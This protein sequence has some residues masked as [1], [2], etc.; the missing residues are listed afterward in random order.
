MTDFLEVIAWYWFIFIHDDQILDQL[1]S[2][3]I[4]SSTR[5]AIASLIG[6]ETIPRSKI[7]H[8]RALQPVNQVRPFLFLLK[9]LAY[10]ETI[11]L[12]KDT[13]RIYYID[14]KNSFD[15]FIVL[16]RFPQFSRQVFVGPINTN[17]AIETNSSALN[18][19]F[20]DDYKLSSAPSI[21]TAGMVFDLVLIWSTDKDQSAMGDIRPSIVKEYDM[22]Y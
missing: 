3:I 22:V 15:E 14:S 19:L 4:K 11:S 7:V 2:F 1:Q 8:L 17:P 6:T 20:I 16:N 9:L 18:V 5:K 21:K 12:P 10:F 13:F